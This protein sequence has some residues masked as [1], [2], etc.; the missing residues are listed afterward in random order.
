M[1]THPTM[2]AVS[3]RP[4]VIPPG[5]LAELEKLQDQIPPFSDE[6]AYAVIGAEL[7]VPPTA[8]FSELTASPIAAAS[9]GQARSVPDMTLLC[10]TCLIAYKCIGFQPAAHQRSLQAVTQSKPLQLRCNQLCLQSCLHGTSVA[11][12]CGVES[13]RQTDSTP[14]LRQVY[15]GILRSNGQ[16]VAVKVQRPGVREQIAMDVFILRNLLAFIREWRKVNR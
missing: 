9:L 14:L 12:S 10:E 6:D 8:L 16:A 7:G 1:T 2:Q 5:Y 3:S 4:D 13:Q 15:R 11:V